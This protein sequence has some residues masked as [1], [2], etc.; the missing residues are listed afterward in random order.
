MLAERVNFGPG[1]LGLRSSGGFSRSRHEGN[2]GR[3]R[4]WRKGGEQQEP[5]SA[6][7]LSVLRV[8]K[9]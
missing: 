1:G 5:V 7:A 3:F 8:A 2:M 6:A 9:A 4:D